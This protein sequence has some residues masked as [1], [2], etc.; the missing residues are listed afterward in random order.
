MRNLSKLRLLE[1]SINNDTMTIS[2][3]GF[4]A[5]DVVY[6]FINIMSY[7]VKNDIKKVI[8][9]FDKYED[10]T[11]P[12]VILPFTGLM[13]L[14][15]EEFEMTF[16][17]QNLHQEN[18]IKTGFPES[19]NVTDDLASISK[20]A[21]HKIIQFRDSKDVNIIVESVFKQ[22]EKKFTFP[23]GVLE[24]A[25]WALSEVMDNVIQH[26]SAHM[27]YVMI[28]SHKDTK[29]LNITVFDNGQG[30]YNS[31][32][33]SPEYADKIHNHLEAIQL[34]LNKNVTRNREIG[35]GFGLWGLTGIIDENG[36]E[37]TI[38]SGTGFVQRRN[39][40]FYTHN[41]G[42]SISDRLLTTRVDVRII[43]DTYLNMEKVFSGY[44]TYDFVTRDAEKYEDENSLYIVFPLKDSGGIRTR[45]DGQEVRN[46]IINL[47]TLNGRPVKVDFTGVDLRV[48][49]SFVD[50][51]V[52]KLFEIYG[53]EQFKQKFKIVGTSDFTNNLIKNAIETRTAA[54]VAK[55]LT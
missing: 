30:I 20:N 2:V 43:Y 31:L 42:F 18:L 14:C 45:K 34:S 33:T 17:V 19:F 48:S 38:A 49:S 41:Y 5:H 12:N 21:F 4:R 6:D 35:Q 47:H 9:D 39:R 54:S 50:E 10:K 22:L 37:L 36:G 32:K 55:I 23:P 13:D 28:Q 51:V 24:G 16:D 15:R 8:L 7:C 52:A 27:A 40:E 1:Y 25:N 3:V 11:Y 29:A 46:K 26:A 53:G 44:K